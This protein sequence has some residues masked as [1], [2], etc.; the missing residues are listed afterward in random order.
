MRSTQRAPL[1]VPR[2]GSAR[3]ASRMFGR[4][5]PRT[6][7]AGSRI[8]SRS[9]IS[10]RTGGAAVAVSASDRRPAERLGRRAEPQVVGPEV[11][12]PLARRSAPRRRRA[13]TARATAS[14]SRTSALASCSGARKTNSSASSASS[15]SASS[16]SRRGDGRVELRGAARGPL[17][18]IVDL[19]ALERDQ[20]RDDDGGARRQQPGDLVDR[21]LA[22]A[23]RHDD[24]RVATVEHRLDRLP[25]ARS[26]RLEAEGLAGDA[27]DAIRDGHRGVAFPG[28]ARAKLAAV[29]VAPAASSR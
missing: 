26:Q 15:A 25:L 4:S 1:A 13:A 14:S 9:T 19:V 23:R 29:V 7:T 28:R 27:V 12:T 11:V 8:P 2:R 6:M 5:K 10:S 20:R 24:E 16:R 3:R 21:R 18:Q 17:A 22:R